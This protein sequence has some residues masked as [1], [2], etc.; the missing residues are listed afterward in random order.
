MLGKRHGEAQHAP[1]NPT[2]GRHSVG[3]STHVVRARAAQSLPSTSTTEPARTH[4]PTCVASQPTK[5]L[6]TL[7]ACIHPARDTGPYDFLPG[8]N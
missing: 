6:A 5:H 3:L 4:S 2:P 1:L 8:E 7:A